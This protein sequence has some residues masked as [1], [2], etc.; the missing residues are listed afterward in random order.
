MTESEVEKLKLNTRAKEEIR[1]KFGLV[2][3]WDRVALGFRELADYTGYN[4]PYTSELRSGR[5][6]GT[7]KFYNNIYVFNLDLIDTMWRPL[8]EDRI[9]QAEEKK[10]QRK[11]DKALMR[12]YTQLEIEQFF[13]ELYIPNYEEK[14]EID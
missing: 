4:L 8:F 9:R 13:E 7:Y 12:A 2:F 1:K 3:G 14:D 5:L 11:Q 6:D 10:L